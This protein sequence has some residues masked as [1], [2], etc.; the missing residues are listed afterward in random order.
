M[1]DEGRDLEHKIERQEFK[2]ALFEMKRHLY[3][4]WLDSDM[5]EVEDCN[6]AN[7][8]I[9]KLITFFSS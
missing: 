3:F 8:C 4:I 1:E 2:K 5:Y 9:D 7:S 6:K